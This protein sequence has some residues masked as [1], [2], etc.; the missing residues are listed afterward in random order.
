MDESDHTEE[1]AV[2]NDENLW[3][4]LRNEYKQLVDAT[5][6]TC[7][8]KMLENEFWMMNGNEESFSMN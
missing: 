6:W 1:E 3:E 5:S 7:R 4:T 2:E 8:L